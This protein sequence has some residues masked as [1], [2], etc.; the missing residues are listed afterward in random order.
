MPGCRD[1]EPLVAPDQ[2]LELGGQPD[3]VPDHGLQPGN[4]VVAQD[5]PELQRPE[6][7]AERYL[8][9]L[10]QN[11]LL[12][13]SFPFKWLPHHIVNGEAGVL[14]LQVERLHVEGAVERAGV[15]HPVA[16]EVGSAI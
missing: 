8:P 6:P 12:L 4:P 9:V 5:E 15:L 7:L 11:N 14:V 2:R 13:F 3:V 10:K 1:L 16:E